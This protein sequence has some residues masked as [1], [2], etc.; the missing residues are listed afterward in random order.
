VPADFLNILFLC[1][2]CILSNV[3]DIRTYSFPKEDTLDD[4]VRLR[5]CILYDYN[6][7]T[8]SDR[9]QFM[10]FRGLALNFI[11]WLNSH[12]VISAPSIDLDL[13]TVEF[14]A[15][16]L[17]AQQARALLNYKI[18]AFAHHQGPPNCTPMDVTRQLN[19]LFENG[20]LDHNPSL[21]KDEGLAQSFTFGLNPNLYAIGVNPDPDIFMGGFLYSH[22]L[23]NIIFIL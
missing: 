11:G 8:P 14:L 10:Y 4:A 17:L 19:L 16:S 18:R 1:N 15:G 9:I 6:A 2:Y 12:F 3:L 23:V 20:I 21:F 5:R 13:L 7:F 22:C